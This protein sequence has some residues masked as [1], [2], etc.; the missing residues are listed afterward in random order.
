M[1]LYRDRTF[2][3]LDHEDS[4]PNLLE[5]I[6]SVLITE[7]PESHLVPSTMRAQCKDIDLERCP[8]A[9]IELLELNLA[10][11]ISRT[12]NKCLLFISNLANVI[13]I[14]TAQID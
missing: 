12:V 3:T 1:T 10:F 8:R 2:E 6:I 5:H 9:D 13:F 11:T 4:D 14:N 7:V